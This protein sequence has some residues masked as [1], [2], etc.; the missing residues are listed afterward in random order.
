[1]QLVLQEKKVGELY[2][3]KSNLRPISFANAALETPPIIAVDVI[4]P[5]S[6]TLL[7]ALNPISFLSTFHEL[8]YYAANKSQFQLTCLSGMLVDLVE[9]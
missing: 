7:S 8:K 3:I 1:M 4:T 9:L 6:I 2:S 5:V